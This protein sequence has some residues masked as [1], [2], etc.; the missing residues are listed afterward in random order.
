RRLQDREVLLQ[1]FSQLRVEQ[2]DAANLIE[3]DAAQFTAFADQNQLLSLDLFGALPPRPFFDADYDAC[4]W[5]RARAD[6][7]ASALQLA[8]QGGQP[9]SVR[10]IETDAE[11]LQA[12]I[13]WFNRIESD[14]GYLAL[15]GAFAQVERDQRF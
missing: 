2:L 8:E 7:D 9:R 4:G 12:F 14:G 11:L 15:I 1:V 10:R 3:R 6:F 13:D 5:T